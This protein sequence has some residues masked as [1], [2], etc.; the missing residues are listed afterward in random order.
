MTDDSK[1]NNEFATEIFKEYKNKTNIREQ[2]YMKFME[3]C[4]KSLA[5]Q[6]AFS[7]NANEYI[8]KLTLTAFDDGRTSMNLAE[9]DKNSRIIE[10]DD[11]HFCLITEYDIDNGFVIN[12]N[13]NEKVMITDNSGIAIPDLIRGPKNERSDEWFAKNN[14]ISLP[15]YIEDKLYE[16]TKKKA[17]NDIYNS[18]IN[19]SDY[20]T[21]VDSLSSNDNINMV[22]KWCKDNNEP[23]FTV[24]W[25]YNSRWQSRYARNPGKFIIELDW[26]EKYENSTN[27]RKTIQPRRRKSSK[28]NGRDFKYKKKYEVKNLTKYQAKKAI[29]KS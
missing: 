2:E 4:I 14:A 18:Q 6:I 9:F 23:I 1:S 10:I 19:D 28:Y 5:H 12:Q 29:K 26:G 22:D 17:L 7:E 15:K 16:I 25:H 13:T 24:R 27:N 3:K 8:T 21:W 11:E 20:D